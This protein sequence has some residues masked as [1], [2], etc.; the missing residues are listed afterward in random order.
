METK[1]KVR[2]WKKGVEK[3]SLR[4][5]AEKTRVM[6]CKVSKGQ[7]EDSGVHPCG[8]CRQELVTIQSQA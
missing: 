4:V 8:V 3:K 1:E 2:I 7:V 6:R 5:N